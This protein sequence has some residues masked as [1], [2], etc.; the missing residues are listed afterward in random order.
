M[1]P[2]TKS[3]KFQ[4]ISVPKLFRPFLYHHTI[5][6][7]SRGAGLV[8]STSKSRRTRLSESATYLQAPPWVIELAGTKSAKMFG[9]ILQV[10][11]ARTN[12]ALNSRK[13][14]MKAFLVQRLYLHVDDDSGQ[15]SSIITRC[16]K[17]AL[18]ETY[19]ECH[20]ALVSDPRTHLSAIP[21]HGPVLELQCFCG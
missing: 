21:E 5:N 15:K 10:R 16:E 19:L 18:P 2:E 9:I 8:D 20:T 4:A 1:G 13:T 12:S 14:F 17:D 6:F 3:R 7:C 11:E